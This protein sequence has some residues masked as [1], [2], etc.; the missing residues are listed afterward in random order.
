MAKITFEK[1]LQIYEFLKTV[2]TK[3]EDGHAEYAT[4]WTDAAVAKHMGVTE[5]NVYY[6]RS[7]QFGPTRKPPGAGDRGEIAS[8]Q[9]AVEDLQKR[10]FKLEDALGITA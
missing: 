10:L 8:L 3:L 9:R 1:R 2:C 5:G 7:T 4:G 6:L